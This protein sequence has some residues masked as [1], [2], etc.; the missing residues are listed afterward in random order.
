MSYQLTRLLASLSLLGAMLVMSGATD[1]P[2]TSSPLVCVEVFKCTGVPAIYGAPV[3]CEF[4]YCFGGYSWLVP[5][6]ELVTSTG[7]GQVD[8]KVREGKWLL[9]NGV[10]TCFP[11]PNGNVI[12][13]FPAQGIVHV[14]SGPCLPG[15]GEQ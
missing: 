2:A 6:N 14:T 13:S 3:N 10:M 7:W 12:N 5:G 4:S 15:G 1:C 9:V 8:C 11:D